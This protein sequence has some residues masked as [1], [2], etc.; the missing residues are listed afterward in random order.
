MADSKD[1]T[2]VSKYLTENATINF[3]NSPPVRGGATI[4]KLFSWEYGGCQSLNHE[5]VIL[6]VTL[7]VGHLTICIAY[8][9]VSGKLKL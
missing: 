2:M 3:A 9:T 1:I 8:K 7:P 5:C 4:E 6:I